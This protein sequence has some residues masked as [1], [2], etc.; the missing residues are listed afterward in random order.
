MKSGN[1]TYKDF[2][3]FLGNYSKV[4]N[5]VHKVIPTISI[6]PYLSENKTFNDFSNFQNHTE[7]VNGKLVKWHYRMFNILIK[8]LL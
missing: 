6:H 8:D 3:K 4:L 2:N 5:K 7:K 1:R